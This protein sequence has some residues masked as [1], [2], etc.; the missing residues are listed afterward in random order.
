MA[1]VWT[2]VDAHNILTL[3]CR[4][5][6]GQNASIT[7][8]DTSNFTSVGESLLTTGYENVLNTL[9]TV[10]WRDI[11]AVR[12]FKAKFRTLRAESTGLFQQRRR[13]ISYFAK[14]PLA[15]GNFNTDLY[16]N[17]YPLFTAGEN[18]DANGVP[19]STKS[20]WEQHPPVCAQY[21]FGGSSVWQDCITYYLDKLEVAF[22]D[23]SSFTAFIDGFVTERFNDIETQKESF[24][25]MNLLNTI[26][27]AIDMTASMPGTVKDMTALFNTYMGGTTYTRDQILNAHLREFTAFF[28]AEMK[29]DILDMEQRSVKYHINPAKT[30]DGVTYN[31]LRHTPRDKQRLLMYAPFWN[32]VEATVYS[33]VFN[34]NWLK[35]ENFEAIAYW[36]NENEGAKIDIVPSV[37]DLV[38][39]VQVAGNNVQCDYVLGTLQDVDALWVDYQLENARTSTLESRK[40]YYNTW[41]NFAFNACNDL[42]EKMIVY[43]MN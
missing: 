12:P 6:T 26:A 2:P 14:D 13:K 18:P 23:E 28:I 15:S 42:T 39:G 16:T 29:N 27:G 11:I 37:P 3:M 36:Q 7:T 33:A 35:P 24:A 1:R 41:L 40:G 4:E 38:N 34:E 43:I 19:Q 21:F 5:I 30:I 31:L 20:Q 25:R 32:L 10:I 22:R 9:S 8:V 17:A